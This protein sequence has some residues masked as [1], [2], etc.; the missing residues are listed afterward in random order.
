MPGVGTESPDAGLVQQPSAVRSVRGNLDCRRCAA[1]AKAPTRQHVVSCSRK[2]CLMLL[3]LVPIKH[4]ALQLQSSSGATRSGPC[5][6][7]ILTTISDNRKVYGSALSPQILDMTTQGVTGPVHGSSIN[8][9]I[10]GRQQLSNSI[11][12]FFFRRRE[13]LARHPHSGC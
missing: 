1:H 13:E 9:N 5:E 3:A 10:W 6:A 12:N 11:L 7:L 8:T 2:R 4:R